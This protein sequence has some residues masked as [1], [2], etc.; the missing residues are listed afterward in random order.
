MRLVLNSATEKE[1]CVRDLAKGMLHHIY[2]DQ[3]YLAMTQMVSEWAYPLAV[4]VRKTFMHAISEK[5]WDVID[6][7]LVPD[8][9]SA[10]IE[11]S[12][13]NFQPPNIS[14]IAELAAA[15]NDPLIVVF[16]GELWE[17]P[18][19]TVRKINSG[20]N[21]NL[22]SILSQGLH[23]IVQFELR[24]L[25]PEIVVSRLL[26]ADLLTP[27]ECIYARRRI[28]QN[29]EN[30]INAMSKTGKAFEHSYLKSLILDDQSWE[31]Q[32]TSLVQL[33]S[34]KRNVRNEISIAG[35]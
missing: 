30:L 17:M 4:Q 10:V 28:T 33:N 21:M 13:T 1:K 26:Q 12:H 31:K 19:A 3:K 7:A 34:Y 24:L 5:N 9:A 35:D 2:L 16:L 22:I 27:R 14:H 8:V 15:L 6:R 23:G 20:W 25:W 32:W 29:I 11:L 18:H